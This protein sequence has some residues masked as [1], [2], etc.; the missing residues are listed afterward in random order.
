MPELFG[1]IAYVIWLYEWIIIISIVLS[2]L[3]QMDMINKFN[4]TVRGIRQGLSA[5][6]EPLL[7]PIRRMMPDT[8]AIDFAPVILLVACFGIR[9]FLIPFL[10]RTLA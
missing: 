1:F 7:Q 8:G 6:T 5:V 10:I 3:A 9:G 4:P 2:W